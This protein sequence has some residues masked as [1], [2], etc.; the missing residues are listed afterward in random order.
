MRVAGK[1]K[2][3]WTVLH[4]NTRE[5]HVYTLLWTLR[6]CGDA[7]NLPSTDRTHSEQKE[8]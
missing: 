1:F 2:N 7:T 3:Q 8:G 5:Q 6:I 4:Q